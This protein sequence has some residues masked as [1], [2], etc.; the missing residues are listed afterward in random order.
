M[1]RW[2]VLA[3]TNVENPTTTPFT[4]V[5][6]RYMG[7]VFRRKGTG[8]LLNQH[9]LNAMF[10]LDENMRVLERNKFMDMEVSPLSNGTGGGVL[11]AYADGLLGNG[12]GAG[13]GP[14]AKDQQDGVKQWKWSQTEGFSPGRLKSGMRTVGEL[15]RLWKYRN[16]RSP[17]ESEGGM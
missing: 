9:Y 6:N 14:T 5:P 15:S 8:H 4:D 1:A 3:F 2:G 17:E 12:N 7:Q 10:P 11:A 16:G 13:G